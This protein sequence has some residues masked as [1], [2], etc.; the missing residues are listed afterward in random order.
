MAVHGIPEGYPKNIKMLF[1]GSGSAHATKFQIFQDSTC[2]HFHSA[3][4]PP[5]SRQS[6]ISIQHLGCATNK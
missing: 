3:G 2:P 1:F 5:K 4:L 6:I